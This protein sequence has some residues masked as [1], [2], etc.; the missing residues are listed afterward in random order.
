MQDGGAGDYICL[1]EHPRRLRDLEYH[2]TPVAIRG[3]WDF[4]SQPLGPQSRV[5]ARREPNYWI[6][7]IVS[8]LRPPTRLALIADIEKIW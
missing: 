2:Q 4:R 6:T 3:I 1:E 7:T 8:V 5:G